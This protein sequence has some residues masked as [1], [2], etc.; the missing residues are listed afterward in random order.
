M[1][2]TD[3]H[4]VSIWVVAVGWAALALLLNAWGVFEPPTGQPPPEQT[5]LPGAYRQVQVH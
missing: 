3:H 4:T 2:S 1:T 5:F